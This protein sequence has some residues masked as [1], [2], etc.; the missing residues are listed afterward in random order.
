LANPDNAPY[1]EPIQRLVRRLLEKDPEAR[2]E[3]G[4][5]ALELM[6]EIR[7]ELAEGPKPDPNEGITKRFIRTITGIFGRKKDLPS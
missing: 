5:K 3:N 4:A 2:P 1:P 7:K 6:A